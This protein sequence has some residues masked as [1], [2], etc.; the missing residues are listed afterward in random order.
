MYR[1]SW[2]A[3]YHGENDAQGKTDIEDAVDNFSAKSAADREA[4]QK[5]STK[6]A[7]PHITL[8]NI[9]AES[10][11][12]QQQVP[13]MQDHVMFMEITPQQQYHISFQQNLPSIPP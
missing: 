13:K 3:G 9:Q 7:Q 4:F 6:N 1:L 8:T 5:L 11:Y 2:D 10:S 12:L